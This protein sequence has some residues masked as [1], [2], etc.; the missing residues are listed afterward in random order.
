MINYYFL[1]IYKKNL[2]TFDTITLVLYLYEK[3]KK[4]RKFFYT[5]FV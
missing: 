2:L 4:L 5:K 1:L 3:Y